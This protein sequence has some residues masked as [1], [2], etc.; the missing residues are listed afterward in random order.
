MLRNF[1]GSFVRVSTT[2]LI[3][4]LWQMTVHTD[5]TSYAYLS[6]AALRFCDDLPIRIMQGD[7]S[8]RTFV[9]YVAIL[10]VMIFVQ[11]LCFISLGSVLDHLKS[12]EVTAMGMFPLFA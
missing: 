10:S 2:S 8:N 12:T 6:W 7:S 4:I 11:A 5:P 9:V 1:L 3:S